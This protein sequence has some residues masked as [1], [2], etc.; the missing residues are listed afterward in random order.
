MSTASSIGLAFVEDG[1]LLAADLINTEVVIRRKAYD[2][3]ATPADALLWFETMRALRPDED[4]VDTSGT[5]PP[6]AGA[7]V[8]LKALRTWLRLFFG[9]LTNG[10]PPTDAHLAKLNFYLKSAQIRLRHTP[11]HVQSSRP[12][13]T[14]YATGPVPGAP[15][16]LACAL[17]A[18]HLL[19]DLDLARLHRCHNP[20]CVMFFYDRTRSATRSWCSLDCKDRERSAERYRLKSG[21]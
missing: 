7:L 19:T 14:L 3:L 12:A 11:A 20:A 17:S 15:I 18:A 21:G 16:A 8:G 4:R 1:D 6:D 2:L 9:E 13:Q 5:L 10:S